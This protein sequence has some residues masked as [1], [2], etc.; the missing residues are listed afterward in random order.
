M[1]I[2]HEVGNEA[3]RLEDHLAVLGGG[4]KPCILAFIGPVVEHPVIVGVGRN[5]HDVAELRGVVADSN[6]T[7]L[8][9]IGIGGDA[10]LLEGEV[11]GEGHRLVDG[12]DIGVI[13][14]DKLVAVVP[15][16]EMAILANR[17]SGNHDLGVV[18]DGDTV[19]SV[20]V[21]DKADSTHVNIVGG[22]GEGHVFGLIDGGEFDII[23]DSEGVGVLSG[24]SFNQIFMIIFIIQ[25]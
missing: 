21:A 23:L 16:I 25:D 15:T 6:G 20:F 24:N 9:R 13:L 10:I 8:P 14:A 7:S 12:D 1:R 5:G 2:A 3:Q 17:L 4:G 22:D 19:A 18:V 11:G